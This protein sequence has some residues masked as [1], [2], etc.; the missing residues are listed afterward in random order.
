MPIRALLDTNV[1]IDYYARR[2]PFFD[3]AVTLRYA[4]FFGDVEL[5]TCA[6]SFSDVEYV[7]RRALPIEQLREMV[8]ESLGFLHV[9]SPTASDIE[10]ALVSG[11]P[12]LEDFLVMRCAQHV[13]AGYLVTRD[14]KG[15]KLSNVP[16]LS[17]TGFI[18]MLKTE[19]GV[20]YEKAAL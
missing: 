12:D 6:Q 14:E 17:P 15:F 16:V 8:R 2:Q 10:D 5:W 18:R 4:S 1:L 19:H 11:W 3:A 20:T 13:K 7:L 9:F